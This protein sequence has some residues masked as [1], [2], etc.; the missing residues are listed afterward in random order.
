MNKTELIDRVEKIVN[1]STGIARRHIEEAVNGVL[2]TVT[3]TLAKGE[4]VNLTG[5]GKFSVKA[6]AARTGRNPKTGAPVQIVASKAVKFTPGK[7]L[8]ESVNS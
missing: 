5:F 7:G 1:A 2:D 3:N 4:D 8:K 6:R